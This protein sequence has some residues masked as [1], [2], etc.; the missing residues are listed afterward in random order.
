MAML[1]AS[2]CCLFAKQVRYYDY[3]LM[4]GWVYE[5]EIQPRAKERS[6]RTNVAELVAPL[7]VFHGEADIDVPYA[8]VKAFVEAAR[9]AWP[10]DEP[11]APTLEFVSFEGEGHGM[12]SWKP[13]TRAAAFQQLK[14]FL[15]I[16]VKPW[17]FTDNPHGHLTA[18]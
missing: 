10:R 7:L 17:D 13:A 4:G 3:A 5:P 11:G 15:R 1:C 18:Y 14:D 9:A 2:T 12:G 16:H 8:Q 6:P